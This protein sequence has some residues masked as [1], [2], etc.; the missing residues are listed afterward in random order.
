[1]RRSA[2]EDRGRITVQEEGLVPTPAQQR[3]IGRAES[4]AVGGLDGLRRGSVERQA[5]EEEGNGLPSL[6]PYLDSRQQACGLAIT[7]QIDNR[8]PHAAMVPR[9]SCQRLVQRDP[10]LQLALEVELQQLLNVSH[11]RVQPLALDPELVVRSVRARSVL[12]V[13]KHRGRHELALE[14]AFAGA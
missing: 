7:R 8:G 9:Q 5:D 1:M 13:R 11:V 14:D 3:E 4:G 12:S 10:P 2:P 6:T